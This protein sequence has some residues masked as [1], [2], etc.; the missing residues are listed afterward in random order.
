METLAKLKNA[1]NLLHF[2]MRRMKRKFNAAFKTQVA[3]ETHP[4]SRKL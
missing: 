2:N 1:I 4:E 3:I